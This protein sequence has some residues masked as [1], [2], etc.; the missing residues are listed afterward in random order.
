MAGQDERLTARLA[1]GCNLNRDMAA[2]VEAGG[3][4]ITKLDAYYAKGDL[5]SQGWTFQGVATA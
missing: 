4:E 1:C 3:F 5:K 2:I